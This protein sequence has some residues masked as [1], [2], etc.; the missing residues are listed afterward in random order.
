[1]VHRHNDRIKIE[2]TQRMVDSFF[3]AKPHIAG[4]IVMIIDLGPVAGGT[5]GRN[6]KV[7]AKRDRGA[8]I[9]NVVFNDLAHVAHRRAVAASC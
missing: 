7:L 3:A 2:R 8:V 4:A 5:L 1:M 9:G 6:Q